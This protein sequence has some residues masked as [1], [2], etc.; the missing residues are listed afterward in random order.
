MRCP[1]TS[2]TYT[3]LVGFPGMPTMRPPKGQLGLELPPPS[4]IVC[5]ISIFLTHFLCVAHT[6]TLLVGFP[7]VPTMHPPKGI[8]GWN[9]PPFKYSMFEKYFFNQFFVRCPYVYPVSG[10]SRHGKYASFRAELGLEFAPSASNVVRCEK[11]SW[12]VAQ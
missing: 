11:S 6:Y 10:V 9:F 5:L 8:C 2:H 1:Y 12:C 3:L 7:G 4:N